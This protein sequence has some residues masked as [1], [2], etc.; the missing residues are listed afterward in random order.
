MKDNTFL[1]LLIILITSILCIFLAKWFYDAVMGT[2][3]PDWVKY[4]V[5]R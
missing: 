5:L 3:W 4:L 2:D 1:E